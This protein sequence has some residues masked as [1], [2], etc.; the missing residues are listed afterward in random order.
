MFL[1]PFNLITKKKVVV[2]FSLDIIHTRLQFDFNVC[3]Y[4][5]F[6]QSFHE[7]SIIPLSNGYNS[8]VVS[9]IVPFGTC[10]AS[11]LLL[12][13]VTSPTKV[14]SLLIL[15]APLTVSRLH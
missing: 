4:H 12:I 7:I 8:M 9:L 5:H 13:I 6:V 14:V 10:F 3:S 2:K 15:T 1:R 11:L